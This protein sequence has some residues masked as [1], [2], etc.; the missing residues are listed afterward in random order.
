MNLKTSDFQNLPTT[1]YRRFMMLIQRKKVATI[2]CTVHVQVVI[3]IPCISLLGQVLLSNSISNFGKELPTTL[4][5]AR[6]ICNCNKDSFVR[7]VTC[8]KCKMLY[9]AEHCH[10]KLPD[11]ILV[12]KKC[13]FIEYPHHPFPAYYRNPCGAILMKQ[14]RTSAGKSI[15]CPRQIF[16]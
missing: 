13:E 1:C 12:S 11:K 7:Y 14:V 6:K 3:F 16:C 10:I 5:M 9:S 2:V 8:P 4:Y 15:L